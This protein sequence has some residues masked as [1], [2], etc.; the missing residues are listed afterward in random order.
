MALSL[1]YPLATEHACE[2]LREAGWP[3]ERVVRVNS[4]GDAH[5]SGPEIL[6]VTPTGRAMRAVIEFKSS[7]V[8]KD[9]EVHDGWAL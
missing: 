8:P 2:V 5:T 7:K 6:Y 9:I 4:P 3:I 1:R